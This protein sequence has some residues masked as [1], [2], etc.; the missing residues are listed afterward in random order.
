VSLSVSLLI[1]AN[2]A[3]RIGHAR[4]QA[5]VMAGN[6]GFSETR[7]SELGIVVTE[8]AGNIAAHASDGEIVLSPWEFRGICGIDVLAL[9][10]GAGMVDVGRSLEDGYS[11]SGTAGEGLGAISR[12]AADLQIYSV[13]GK[14]TALWARVTADSSPLAMATSAAYAVGAINLP[15]LGEIAC[16]DGWGAIYSST[17]SVYMIADG[18]GHGPAAEEAAQEA[19]RVFQAALP[20]HS[21]ARILQDAH[22]ALAKTRGAAVAIAEVLHDQGVVN[23]AGVGNIAGSL[24]F[25]AK[26]RSMVSMNGILGHQMGKLQSFSYPW[27]KNTTLLMH[28]D[29]LATRWSLDQYP[30]LSARHPA[31]Q[32]AMLYRDFSRRRDDVTVLISRI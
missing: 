3:S 32:A 9:D 23:Y 24:V 14:G 16:G 25:N 6:L 27:Q 22:G 19:L 12:L 2:D 20:E 5:L 4:R 28:S 15:I 10:K 26:S 17:R 30:G 13:P 11:T 31:L 7:A 29:G 21:I 18:L 8:A 1:G